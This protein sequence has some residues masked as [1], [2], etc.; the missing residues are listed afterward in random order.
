[1]N[2]KRPNPDLL[3]KQ[4]NADEIQATRGHLKIFFGASAGV[5]KTYAML[6]AAHEALKQEIPLV[7]GIV[8]THG[9][10]ETARLTR[11]L[12]RLDLKKNPLPWTSTGRI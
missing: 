4:V 6:T 3:L 5:G 11:D 2:D 8:E 10:T 12:P 9:R 7:M 1:M